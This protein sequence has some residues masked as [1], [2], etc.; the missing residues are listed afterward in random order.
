MVESDQ[1]GKLDTVSNQAIIK[2]IADFI[3]IIPQ[4]NQENIAITEGIPP[5]TQLPESNQ[6]KIDSLSVLNQ[7]ELINSSTTEKYRKA[8]STIETQIHQAEV[9]HSP[10]SPLPAVYQR[11]AVQQ[12]NQTLIQTTTASSKAKITP[13]VAQT[14]KAIQKSKPLKP[15]KIAQPPRIKKIETPTNTTSKTKGDSVKTNLLTGTLKPQSTSSYSP[16]RYCSNKTPPK[17]IQSVNDT[18]CLTDTEYPMEDIV[19]CIHLLAC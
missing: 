3:E 16:L 17:C 12:A 2:E 15:S 18:F 9:L 4:S 10:Q 1:L 6:L 11:K 19:V 14:I 13:A 8:N 5:T 7:T